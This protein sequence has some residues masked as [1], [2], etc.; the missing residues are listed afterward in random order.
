MHV[1]KGSSGE[2]RKS[3]HVR[4]RSRWF[5][6]LTAFALVATLG[7]AG[8]SD[9]S[10]FDGLPIGT[11]ESGFSSAEF[12][13]VYTIT[14]SRINKQDSYSARVVYVDDSQ[15]NAGDTSVTANGDTAVNPGFAV[16]KYLAVS[17]P[18]W[19]EVGKYNVFRWADG[20]S[21]N[22]RLMT[23][24]GEYTG[25]FEDETLEMVVFDS[26]EN[27]KEGATNDEG[28]FGFAGEYSRQ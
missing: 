15:L 20:T 23:Q 25:S 5:S 16:I 28:F 1:F 6:V 2:G 27:A 17:G 9:G 13:D 26:I 24:G 21:A 22:Q 14:R 11:W 18:S 3:A 4:G 19:G 12:P 8:C 10:G 7:L